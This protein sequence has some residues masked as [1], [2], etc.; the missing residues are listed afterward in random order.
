MALKLQLKREDCLKSVNI[1]KDYNA[2]ALFGWNEEEVYIFMVE[3]SHVALCKYTIT[4]GFSM[5][6]PGEIGIK[7]DTFAGALNFLKQEEITLTVE[8]HLIILE[9]NQDNRLEMN[10]IEYTLDKLLIEIPDHTEMIIQSEVLSDHL[11]RCKT[12]VESKKNKKDGVEDNKNMK[13][14]WRS[15]KDCYNIEI[16]GASILLNYKCNFNAVAPKDDGMDITVNFSASYKAKYLFLVMPLLSATQSVTMF[17]HKDHPMVLKFEF[18]TS[19]FEV[20]M[21]GVIFA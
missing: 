16:T 2:D 20:A 4:S 15:L 19:Q 5:T 3:S 1:M 12:L 17:C 10:T 21:A 18:D 7:L 13:F 11:K 6:E 9:D 8:E 14:T